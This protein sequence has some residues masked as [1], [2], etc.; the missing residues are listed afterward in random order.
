MFC[1]RNKSDRKR[2]RVGLQ[3]P[4]LKVTVAEIVQ[5]TP[6]VKSFKLVGA[7]GRLPRFSGGAHITTYFTVNAETMER[8]YSLVGNPQRDD[9]Y[10]IAIR[11]SET[12]RGG[13]AH[14]H[15]QIRTGDEIEISYPKNHL[16]V[17]F[18]AKHHVFI[19]AGIG[20]TP[21]MAMMSELAASGKSFELHDAAASEAY[22]PFYEEIR[23]RYGERAKFYFSGK[24]QRLPVAVMWKQPIG[25][26]VYFCGPE[27]MISQFRQAAIH[28][29]YPASNIHYELFSPPNV[30]P[31]YPFQAVLAKSNVTLQVPE[32][33]SLLEV[34]L[35]QGIA[36]AYSCKIG[37]CG[38]CEIEVEDGEVDHRD[39][40]LSE[41]E[42]KTRKVMIP[43]ISRAKSPL[44]INL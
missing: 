21:F 14:W 27:E 40:F 19:A 9:Y 13:S 31:S 38:S 39:F 26:H 12:S 43:C 24:Q 17:S 4:R 44:I 16:P 20:I 8:H 6:V 23:K 33:K 10:T 2:R 18:E 36:A 7:R 15:D 37:G 30:G 32:S 41:Q 29:G 35:E 28:Y 5:E 22:C 42:K 11:R 3:N 1:V 34:M 25:T